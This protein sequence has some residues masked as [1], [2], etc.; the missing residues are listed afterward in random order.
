[1]KLFRSDQIKQIDEYTIKEEPVASIDLMERAAGQLL[2]WYL[3]RFGRTG[4]IFIF[5]GPGNNGGDGL[6]LAR[7]LRFNRY[8]VDVFYINLTE[9]TSEDSRTNLSRLKSET[10]VEV[11]CLSNSVRF[12]VIFSGDI[13][14]DAIFGSGLARPV[15]GLAA[16]IIKL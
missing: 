12:P 7:M 4:H 3:S 13:I 6:A 16:E 8:D 2:K 15:E 10:D 1:M 14:I 9:K 11:T 5:A